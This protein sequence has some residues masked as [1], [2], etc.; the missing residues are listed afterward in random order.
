[1]IP[2]LPDEIWMK[3]LY[4]SGFHDV[5]NERCTLNLKHVLDPEEYEDYT[6]YLQANGKTENDVEEHPD[7]TDLN[8]WGVGDPWCFVGPED[9]FNFLFDREPI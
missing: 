3:I 4:Y 1:M 2:P 9:Q 7:A 5:F 8:E 6:M